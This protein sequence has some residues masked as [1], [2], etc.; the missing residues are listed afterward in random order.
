M[1]LRT[2]TF[3]RF[4]FLFFLF[5]LGAHRFAVMLDAGHAI[6]LTRHQHEIEQVAFKFGDKPSHALDHLPG[7]VLKVLSQHDFT[8][9]LRQLTAIV[10]AALEIQIDTFD[11]ISK[12][13]SAH[14][15]THETL[16][17]GRQALR[18]IAHVIHQ[19]RRLFHQIHG[20]VGRFLGHL[21][22]IGQAIGRVGNG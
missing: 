12:L 19:R 10:H 8:E 18:F 16:P 13:L 2:F 11:Q 3:G 4:F 1:H 9:V 17:V 21:H 20:A 7:Q 14:F 22:H 5:L 6:Y 15:A